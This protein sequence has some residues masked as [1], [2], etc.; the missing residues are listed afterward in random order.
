[1]SVSHRSNSSAYTLIFPTF[2]HHSEPQ[3]PSLKDKG[4]RE[5][6]Q[7]MVPQSSLPDFRR[8]ASSGSSVER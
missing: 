4:C 3:Q 6:R 2:G 7:L 1:M 8:Q 5:K